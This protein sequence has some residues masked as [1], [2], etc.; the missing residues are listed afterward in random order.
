[1]KSGKYTHTGVI[2]TMTKNIISL[3]RRSMGTVSV[4]IDF[5][6]EYCSAK[7]MNWKER[8]LFVVMEKKL[9]YNYTH[10]C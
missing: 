5:D 9:C 10:W 6:A 7:F 1:M 3:N 2:F 4:K 8:K